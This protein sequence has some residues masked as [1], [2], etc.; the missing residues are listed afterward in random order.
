MYYGHLLLLQTTAPQQQ[1]LPYYS[2]LRIEVAPAI[3]KHFMELEEA[4][5]VATT[6]PTAA[7]F[8]PKNRARS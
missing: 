3:R 7:G 5:K 1:D 8:Q 2:C 4:Q 6:L